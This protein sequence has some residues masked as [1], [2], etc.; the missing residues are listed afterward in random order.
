MA[1]FTAQ[2][3]NVG[4]QDM[5]ELRYDMG[6][7]VGKHPLPDPS[8]FTGAESDLDTM[9]ERDSTGYLHRCMVAT[10][11]PL[12]ME[13]TNISWETIQD[14]CALLRSP[15]FSFTYPD[16]FTGGLRTMEAYV[17]DR[18]FDCVWAPTN[19]VYIGNL[20]FSVIEY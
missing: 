14:I 9:G 5:P 15:K 17:G 13:Y 11:F 10:K 16:P 1:D 7:S 20:R 19:G 8:S 2:D 6:F 3:R 18:D 12:K 4:V